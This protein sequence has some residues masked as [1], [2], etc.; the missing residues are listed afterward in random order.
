MEAHNSE[1]YQG[2]PM[3]SDASS[4]Q[5]NLFDASSLLHE[6][7]AASD[8]QAFVDSLRRA[9]A[10]LLPSTRLDIYATNADGTIEQR[11]TTDDTPIARTGPLIAELHLRSW[12]EQ[13]GY[14]VIVMLPLV[15]AG[16]QCGWLVLAQ[17]Q[18]MFLP[19][20]R[21]VADQLAP[22]IAMRLQYE[23]L[24]GDLITS[25]AH[26]AKLERRINTTDALRLR[27]ILAT[28]T[29][30]DIGNIFTTVIGHAQLLQQD[31]PL[32]SQHDIGMII[33][34]AEDG[35][36]LLRRLQS[37]VP[38]FEASPTGLTFLPAVIDEAI[39]L[40]RPLWDRHNNIT[41][42]VN[43]L[44]APFVQALPADLRE[45]LMNL[46][47][48]GVAAMPDG[49]TITVGCH[50]TGARAVVTVA[51]TGHGI[52]LEYQKEIFQP[53]TTTREQGSGL[54]LSVSRAIV[55]GYGGT[56]TVASAPGQGATFT[57]MLP[58][59]QRDRS[60]SEY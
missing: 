22:L 51:D 20:L 42:Q 11:F 10:R 41:I 56:L 36:Y 49:G 28:G 60:V 38:R 59:Y 4:L 35:R 6:L 9:L 2:H 21:T 32:D 54:G 55:E 58:A 17:A 31:M 33:R 44:D 24:Y 39:Q 45:I 13:Q 40:T 43:A 19:L 14:S 53:L 8:W 12:F 15:A 18:R 48:N 34:A 29:A 47:I 1:V 7:A 23:L 26:V 57:I 46:I 27:A 52:P 5:G 25:A 50:V 3:E 30:H 16:R 37:V